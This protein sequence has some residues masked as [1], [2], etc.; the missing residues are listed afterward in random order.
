MEEA[1]AWP[2]E[3][4]QRGHDIENRREEQKFCS[5]EVSGYL[6][7]VVTWEQFLSNGGGEA[8]T[9]EKVSK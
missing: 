1:G 3:T 2:S 5:K 7:S 4:K 6:R 9:D 8:K